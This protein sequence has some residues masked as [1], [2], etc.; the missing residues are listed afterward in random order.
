MDRVC[1]RCKHEPRAGKNRWGR[2]CLREQKR[3]L[4]GTKKAENEQ[5]GFLI[6]E[7]TRQINS[8]NRLVL[9][10]TQYNWLR[11][12]LVYVWLR[13]E[14]PMYVGQSAIG[15]S[16]PFDPKHHAMQEIEDGDRVALIPMRNKQGAE[17]LE[18]AL[19]IRPQ[20]TKNRPRSVGAL[21]DKLVRSVNDKEKPSSHSP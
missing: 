8:S 15:G 7:V 10:E 19:L 5:G 16:R 21:I 6:S 11:G 20:P 12:P 13:G 18:E 14:V 3:R 2:E 9:T 4:R 17:E 1:T